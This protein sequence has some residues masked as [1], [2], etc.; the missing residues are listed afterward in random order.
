VTLRRAAEDL[1]AARIT[2]LEANDRARAEQIASNVD[3]LRE[4]VGPPNTFS[5]EDTDPAAPEM[6]SRSEAPEPK[7][8]SESG[9]DPIVEE[10]LK[11]PQVR[12]AIEGEI[13]K[14]DATRQ[15]YDRA[16]DA[17]SGVLRDVV[18]SQFPELKSD[19]ADQFEAA[20]MQ[21]SQRDPTRY[22]QARA[23]ADR[24]SAVQAAQLLQQQQRDVAQRREFADYAKA[25][26]ARFGAMVKGEKPEVVQRVANEIIAYAEELGVPHEQFLQLCTTEPIMRN[27]AFQKMMFDAASYRLLQ[28]ARN[29]IAKKVVPAVQRPGVAVDARAALAE[30]DVRSL[31]ARFANNPS[32]KNAAEVL[33]AQR[34]ARS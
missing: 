33:T 8:V 14:A 26:D 4:R 16:L 12:E 13:R 17:V 9:I 28:R 24:L 25:E 30:G 29:E 3:E 34:R 2:D 7:E 10:A 31:S 6:T 22:G 19:S 32:I 5:G 27:A 18:F 21:L 11:H 20:L 23:L 15:N 1:T